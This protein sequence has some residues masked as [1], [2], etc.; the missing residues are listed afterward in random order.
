MV[1]GSLHHSPEHTE[2]F[3]DFPLKVHC[4]E[5]I[6]EAIRQGDSYAASDP[7]TILKL[8]VRSH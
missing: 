7:R 2:A 1:S 5:K 6:C 3:S 8:F 4:L